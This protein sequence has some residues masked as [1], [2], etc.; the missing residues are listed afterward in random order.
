MN[1]NGYAI[2]TSCITCNTY[3][4]Y[5]VPNVSFSATSLEQIALWAD[6]CTNLGLIKHTRMKAF[7]FLCQVGYNTPT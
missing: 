6:G 7:G 3:S 1:K 4:Y 2:P 5:N